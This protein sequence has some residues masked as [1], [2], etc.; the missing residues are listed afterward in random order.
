MN[1]HRND[2]LLYILSWVCNPRK[3]RPTVDNII[4]GLKEVEVDVSKRTIER[5][6]R[7]LKDRGYVKYCN[8]KRGYDIVENVDIEELLFVK[9][10]LK[11]K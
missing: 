3:L 11:N 9:I 8:T 5:D 1:N 6:I 4:D 7:Y 10:L 2:R